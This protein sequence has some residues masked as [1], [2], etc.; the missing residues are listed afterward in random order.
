M[1]N[2]EFKQALGQVIYQLR[3]ERG[4][5]QEELALEA[6]VDRTRLGEIERGEANPTIDTLIKIANILSQTLGSL[7]IEAEELSGGNM[8]KPSPTV[9]PEYIDRTVPLP[10]GLTHDQLEQALN[11]SLAILNQIGLN[12]ENGDIQWNIYSGAVSNIVTKSIAETSDFVQNKDTAHPDLYNPNLTS[13]DRDWGLEMKATHQIAKGGESHN[14][15]RCWFIVVVYHIIDS[16]T[17]I[18]Q[19]ETTYLT[20]E[21]WTIH[22][23]AENSSRTRTA[24]TIASATQK[25]RE[26]SVYLD[27]A[28]APPG[29][30]RI[31]QARRQARH[32]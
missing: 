5:S 1:E 23:R 3:K 7:I 32:I 2:A 13:D 12:P 20:K 14:P 8:K 16:Q 19:V 30:K 22:E 21:E 27:P 11:R 6:E 10:K 26:N 25:L 24:V 4:I 9:K 15:G 31:I 18:V 29:L 28:Y 17:H